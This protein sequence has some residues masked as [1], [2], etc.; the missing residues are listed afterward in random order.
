MSAVFGV[1][2][3]I[4]FI[5]LSVIT[6]GD[7]I[8]SLLSA[9]SAMI[10]LGGTLGSVIT[11][12]GPL[13]MIQA[14][15]GIVALVKPAPSNIPLFI[16]QVADWS[17]LARSQGSLSLES[18]LGSTK[19]PFQKKGLQMII[20]NTSQDDLRSIFGILSS[21]ALRSDMVGAE[22]WEAAGGYTPHDWRS[23]RRAWPH[24]RHAAAGSSSGTR[25]RHR[26][27][28][29]S[30]HLRGSVPPISSSSRL[31]RASPAPPPP[32]TASARSSCR[33]SS[34]CRKAS[35]GR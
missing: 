28:L 26:H 14:L 27:R 15:K 16:N 32:G 9:G 1:I 6:G 17:N 4:G 29:H 18:V 35:P 22:F 33:A 11:Q 34:C 24:P 21:N 7:G 2:I 20:D 30:H 3:S 25:A 23:R 5:I 12:F 8:A 10:V 13:A 19:D 31:Q